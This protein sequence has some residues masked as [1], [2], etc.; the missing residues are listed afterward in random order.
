M[1]KT[2]RELDR[3]ICNF[4]TH[5]NA[6]LEIDQGEILERVHEGTADGEMIEKASAEIKQDVE[7]AASIGEGIMLA[8]TKHCKK[9]N[10]KA[11]GGGQPPL[12]IRFMKRWFSPSG[13]G[14]AFEDIKR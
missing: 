14:T 13:D 7:N 9:E 5:K 3:R 11:F 12:H 6:L 8:V 10:Q 1:Q 4:D 2:M